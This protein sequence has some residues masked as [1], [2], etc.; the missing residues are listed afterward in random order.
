MDMQK[1]IND[2]DSP[3]VEQKVKSD[4]LT[5]ESIGLDSTPTFFVN[6]RQI[7]NPANLDGFKQI[8]DE[9]LKKLG[10]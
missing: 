6:G 3:E 2:I 7:A 10:E 9:E 4:Q 5:A 8:I 1:F